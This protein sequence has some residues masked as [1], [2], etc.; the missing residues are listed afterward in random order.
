ML[1]RA[2]KGLDKAMLVLVLLAILMSVVFFRPWYWDATAY[3]LPFSARAMN[4]AKYAQISAIE[5]ERYNGFPVLWR[6][7][8]APGLIFD[9]PRLYVLPNLAAAVAMAF[10]SVATLGLSWPVALAC[11][12]CFPIS[13]LGFASAYQDYFT[14]VIA[15][16]GALHL[17]KWIHDVRYVSDGSGR[18]RLLLSFLFL[19]ISANTKIQGLM[20]SVTILLVGLLYWLVIFSTNKTFNLSLSTSRPKRRFGLKFLLILFWL[21][22]ALALFVQPLNNLIRFGNPLYPV[23]A[24]GLSG[25]EERYSTP[26]EYL[27]KISV[28]TNVISHFL[29]TTEIDPYLLPGGDTKPSLLRSGDMFNE[30]R[31]SLAQSSVRTGGT[32]GPIYIA[33]LTLA[34]AGLYRILQSKDDPAQSS[35]QVALP[36]FALLLAVSALPQS[37]ELRYFLITLYIPAILAVLAPGNA[38][39]TKAAKAVIC[40]GLI[41]GIFHVAVYGRHILAPG[42][43]LDLRKELPTSQQCLSEGELKTGS[44]GRKIL[45]IHGKR[46]GDMVFKCRMVMT[47]DIFINYQR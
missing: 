37:L 24:F 13:L 21:C 11:T 28:V 7:A 40:L 45:N 20:L 23:R 42:I 3:H 9:L 5:N 6:Y 43:M 33:L 41:I 4:L 27:P 29:S 38:W 8:L 34:L 12:L 14:N 32:I 19:I 44:D 22:V 39:S 17:F 2:M 10:S 15:L 18:W 25:S 47:G 26:L 46:F 30:R 36:L 35:D 31:P 16:A 1:V